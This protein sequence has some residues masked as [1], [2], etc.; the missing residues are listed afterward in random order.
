[1][2]YKIRVG[3]L[4]LDIIAM[5]LL[6]TGVPALIINVLGNHRPD[7]PY[8]IPY[9]IF[10]LIP[11]FLF[12][13][14]ILGTNIEI[15]LS[16]EKISIKW[17]SQFIFHNRLDREI[18]FEEI[19]SYK[20][21]PSLNYHLFK[22]KLKDGTKIRLLNNNRRADF[23][24][25]VAD[26]ESLSKQYNHLHKGKANKIMR[27]KTIYETPVGLLFMFIAIALI[28]VYPVLLLLE[29]SVTAPSLGIGIGTTIAGILYFSFLYNMQNRKDDD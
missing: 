12:Q 14:F 10:V 25:F 15:T 7:N 20:Y 28:L 26:F 1:M 18:N 11:F 27:A 16:D 2:V 9:I 6:L 22:L 17:L 19:E 29:P 23:L 21:Q 3:S 13:R 4:I 8:I 5:C 24:R